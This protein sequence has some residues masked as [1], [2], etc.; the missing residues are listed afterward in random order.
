MF[1]ILSRGK[2][3][4]PFIQQTKRE[5]KSESKAKSQEKKLFNEELFKL[6]VL[7]MQNH[8]EEQE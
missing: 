5:K 1:L 6:C 2:I 8:D 3:I 4:I 7:F